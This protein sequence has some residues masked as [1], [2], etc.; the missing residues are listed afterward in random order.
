MTDQDNSYTVSKPK[1]IEGPEDDQIELTVE[2]TD[3]IILTLEDREWVGKLKRPPFLV[4]RKPPRSP[5][6]EVLQ[7]IHDV[8]L[9]IR[10]L[11]EAIKLDKYINPKEAAIECYKEESEWLFSEKV[12]HS[13]S[14]Y[15]W[16]DS[17]K[18]K[19]DFRGLLLQKIIKERFPDL[20]TYGYVTLEKIARS[21]DKK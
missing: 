20:P 10:I 9:Q 16:R 14:I 8:R 2:R 15:N 7:L 5:T 11:W 12:L 3:K 17:G 19:G 4:E 13:R 21:F 6:P 1:I 18:E